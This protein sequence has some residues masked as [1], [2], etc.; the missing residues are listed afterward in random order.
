[1][2]RMRFLGLVLFLVLTVSALGVLST[3]SFH[4]LTTGGITNNTNFTATY[5]DSSETP[6]ISFF[7]KSGSTWAHLCTNSSGSSGFGWCVYPAQEEWNATVNVTATSGGTVRSTAITGVIFDNKQPSISI[8]SPVNKNY[9]NTIN[10]TWNATDQTYQSG[11]WRFVNASNYNQNFSAWNVS[12]SVSYNTS[13]LPN[14]ELVLSVKVRDQF[15]A[16]FSNVTL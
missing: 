15:R 1:M 11:Q 9:S 10:I 12:S 4:S 14:A 2:N 16:A 13:Q 6:S 7:R 5:T 3:V 8:S